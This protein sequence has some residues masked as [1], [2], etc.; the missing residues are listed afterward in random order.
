MLKFFYLIF[1]CITLLFSKNIKITKN[2]FITYN[3]GYLYSDKKLILLFCDNSALSKEQIKILKDLNLSFTI[4]DNKT[5]KKILKISILPTL[6][7]IDKNNTIKYENF[8][9]YE[10]L[11]EEGL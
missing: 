8:T 6:V 3:N 7:I 1:I 4:S 9:P 5:L 2:I 10:I 11:K